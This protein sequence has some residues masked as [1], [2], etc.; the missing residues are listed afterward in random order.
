M[1]RKKLEIPNRDGLTLHAKLE[2]P[3]D[4]KANQY[5]I[6]AH[7]FT[8]NSNFNAV[9]NIARELSNHGFGVVRFDFTGL[10]ESEGDF[11]ETSFSANITDLEDVSA[12]M[13]E[14]LEAPS[15]IVGHSLGG[16]A[17]LVAASR[18]SN[19]KAV[20]TI[21]APAEATHVK[22]LLDKGIEEIES[23]GE[24]KVNIGGRSFLIKKQFLDDLESKDTL[25]IV[26]DLKKPLLI[27]H[28]PQ[29]LIV[30]IDNAAEIYKAAH[31]PKSFISL[32]GADHLLNDKRDSCYAAQ[33]IGTW[34][35]RYL[36]IPVE[37]PLSPKDQQVVAHLNLEDG[38]TTS[39]SNGRHA[40][41]A[42]E[43]PS[44]GGE[45]LGFSPYELI[46]S[47]LGAC[48]AMTLK[49]YAERKEW[50]LREVN[51]Y[52]TYS[53]KHTDD[54]DVDTEQM[55]KVDHILRKIELVGELDEEQRKKLLE[56][57]EK[58]PVHRTLTKSVVVES[59]LAQ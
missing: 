43:P 35:R 39:I 40:I 57:A 33:V 36:E 7:C 3:A 52:L 2:L 37:E 8:C 5:A 1:S 18:L 41:V 54:I 12:Y 31:H 34:V 44:S 9:S 22:L 29:D 30:S 15:L 51:V 11:S 48:T 19:I 42:D 38:F 55:G 50:D 25:G 4:N 24:A 13:K 20:A 21:G 16:T 58:C 26:K 56:I 10:G 32:D 59:E 6:L 23:K 14:N 53:K 45:D 17:A 49:M 47:G 27:L 28:S 46:N